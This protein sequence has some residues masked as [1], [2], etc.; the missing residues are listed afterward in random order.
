MNGLA[1]L[2]PVRLKA[3]WTEDVERIESRYGFTPDQTTKAAEELTKAEAFADDWFLNPENREKRKKYYHDL[4]A[5]QAVERDP[6]ALA[7]QKE[8]RGG[9]AQGT[10]Q[11][12]Q[13]NHRR[14]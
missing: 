9:Q 4:G 3:A 2:D 11:G 10:R 6:L 13:G 12:S 1:K 5:V 8:R 14:T 7:F